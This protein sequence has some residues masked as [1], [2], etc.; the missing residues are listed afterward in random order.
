VADG[1]LAEQLRLTAET[2]EANLG[3]GDQVDRPRPI[4]HLAG[5]RSRSA[6]VAAGEELTAAGY[7]VDGLY[8]RFLTVWL[9]FSAMTAVDHG[10]AAAFTREVVGIVDRHGGRYDGWGGFLVAAESGDEGT[11]STS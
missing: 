8:R 4:D 1:S 11:S 7:R 9:E 6:A 10:T 5:F 3:H 2:V